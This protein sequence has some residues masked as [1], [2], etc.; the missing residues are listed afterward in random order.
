MSRPSHILCL[1]LLFFVSGSSALSSDSC[2]ENRLL[3][4]EDEQDTIVI[5][6]A[7]LNGSLM[8]DLE[9]GEVAAGQTAWP[10]RLIGYSM[11]R[12]L[13]TLYWSRIH[14]I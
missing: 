14:T 1:T 5:H 4:G 8:R 10:L 9:S 12:R 3:R 6:L 7:N 11:K 13:Q 2:F